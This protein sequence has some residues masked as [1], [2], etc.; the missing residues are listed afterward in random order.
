MSSLAFVYDR[1]LGPEDICNYKKESETL[2]KHIEQGD[3]IRLYAPRNFGKT[4]LLKNSVGPRWASN[5]PGQ[6]IVVYVDFYAV[7][8]LADIAHEL[9]AALSRALAKHQTIFEKGGQWLKALKNIRPV[10][11]ANAEGGIDFSL[12]MAGGQKIPELEQTL[13]VIGDLHKSGRFAFFLIFDE[14][15]EISHIA[16]AAAKLRGA[17]QELP[18]TLPVAVLGSKYHL[19]KTVFDQ[20][21]APFYS[22]GLP[23]AL[24]EISYDDYH[25]YMQ[26]RF[27]PA[28]KSI[29]LEAARYLQDRLNRIP[30]SINRIC[31]FI[32]SDTSLQSIGRK[33]IDA[34]IERYSEFAAS[35]YNNLYAQLL[36]NERSLVDALVSLGVVHEI[37]GRD[38][39]LVSK[40]AKSTINAIL[41]RLLDK[42]IVEQIIAG[43]SAAFAYRVT[44]PLFAYF[45]RRFKI[46]ITLQN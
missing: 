33:E 39:L 36:P 30:E 44:D 17:L 27:L 24:N 7:A 26:Q 31:E 38:F 8:S 28:G 32:R 14:F 9:F 19:F 40:L 13:A 3:C 1:L 21:R 41:K 45:V 4:S 43:E 46:P 23:F 34:A 11:S 22:W 10:W 2:L 16:K 37:T 6:R 42:G 5:A 35:L 12:T 25:E 18:A 29:D 15:Q 20:P